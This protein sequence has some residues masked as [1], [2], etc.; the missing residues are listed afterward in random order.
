VIVRT[1]TSGLCAARDSVLPYDPEAVGALSWANG[2][3]TPGSMTRRPHRRLAKKG[4][5]LFHP[6]GKPHRCPEP[7]PAGCGTLHFRRHDG[8]GC[9]TGHPDVCCYRRGAG[10]AAALA[11]RLTSGNVSRLSIAACSASSGCGCVDRTRVGQVNGGL[12]G[13]SKLADAVR[14]RMNPASGTPSPL[15]RAEAARLASGL[16]GPVVFLVTDAQDTP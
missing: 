10:A 8:V 5:G 6:T 14:R 7:Q 16:R 2:T 11:V 12:G 13:A 3:S 15:K 9:H 1:P 4:T